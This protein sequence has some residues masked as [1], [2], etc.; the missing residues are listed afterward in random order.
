ML[1]CALA[2]E[3][4]LESNLARHMAILT[5]RQGG[6]CRSTEGKHVDIEPKAAIRGLQLEPVEK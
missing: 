6:A 4:P 2:F 1:W 5:A 3:M